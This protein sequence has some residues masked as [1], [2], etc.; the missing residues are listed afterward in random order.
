M[1]RGTANFIDFFI[2]DFELLK[3]RNIDRVNVGVWVGKR[4]REDK[5]GMEQEFLIERE[6][7]KWAWEDGQSF[8][9]MLYL[10]LMQ[11]SVPSSWIIDYSVSEENEA[12]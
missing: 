5:K 12:W 1:T 7:M 11:E 10:V 4:D 9:S 3:C 2:Y 6:M 8:L